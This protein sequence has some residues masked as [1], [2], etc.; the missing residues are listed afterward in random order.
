VY[1]TWANPVFLAFLLFGGINNSR[2]FI[3]LFTSIPTA[4]TNSTWTLG[5]RLRTDSFDLHSRLLEFSYFVGLD[6]RGATRPEPLVRA[7]LEDVLYDR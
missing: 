3:I 4:P 5:R 2:L 6:G 7:F 1:L